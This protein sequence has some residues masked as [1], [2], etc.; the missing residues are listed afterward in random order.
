MIVTHLTKLD[1]I[2]LSVV[3]KRLIGKRMIIYLT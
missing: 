3:I 1:Q 2:R